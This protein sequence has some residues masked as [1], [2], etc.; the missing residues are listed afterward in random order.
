MCDERISF[1]TDVLKLA[2]EPLCKKNMAD[3]LTQMQDYMNSNML[4]FL[5]H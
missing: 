2:F 4:S 3:Q 5:Q 1:L